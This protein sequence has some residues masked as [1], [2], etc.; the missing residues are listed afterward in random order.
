MSAT[1]GR[2]RSLLFLLVPAVFLVAAALMIAWRASAP[3]DGTVVTV[4]DA[5]V[6][7]DGVRVTADTGGELWVGDEIVAIDGTELADRLAG[8][9]GGPPVETG[10][11]LSYDVLRDGRAITVDVRLEPAP[12][13]DSLLAGWPSLLVTALLLLTSLAIFAARPRD[14]AAHAAITASAIGIATVSGAGYFQVE[15]IDL[16]AGGQFWRWFAGEICFALLWAAMLHFALAFPA[17]TDRRNYRRR[18]LAGYAGSPLLYAMLGGFAFLAADDPVSRLSL[19][20]SPALGALAVYPLLIVGVLVA[21]YVRHS[22][23]ML[24]RRLRWLATSLGGGALIYLAVWTI[25]AA[26]SGTPLV[27]WE[28]QTLA[29]LAVPL[30]VAMAIVRHRAL[31]IEVVISRSLVYGALSV[32]L[33][34]L[35]AGVVGL[36]HL[37]FGGQEQLWQQA[38]AAAI[39]AMAV[40]PLHQLLQSLVNR[41]LF[42]EQHDPY[43]VVSSLADRLENIGAPSEQLPVMVETIGTAL[44]LPYVAIELEREI[45]N[46]RVAAFGEPTTNLHSLPLSYQREIIGHLVIG[47]RRRWDGLGR[48]ERQVLEEVARHAGT[49]VYTAKLTA[50]LI[51]SRDRLVQAR[52]EERKRVQ[53][54]L[55]DGVG[56]TLAAVTFGLH[57]I[58]KAIG[59]ASPAAPMLRRLQD[60]LNGA[61]TE[62][63]RLAHGLRPPALDQVGLLAATREYLETVG[64]STGQPRDLHIEFEAPSS[65]P[66]LPPAV[67]V[68]AYRIVCEAVTNVRRHAQASNCTVR[69][70]ADDDL[71]IAV[72]DDGVGIA[73]GNGAGSGIGLRSMRERTTE[74]GGRFRIEHPRSGGTSMEVLLP[75]GRGGNGR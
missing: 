62:V 25:P 12:V 19:A 47:R 54:E 30:A 15:A 61:T 10:Q 37:L 20:G 75:I 43:R 11:V 65:L 27:P 34:T 69:L 26:V 46:E 13:G 35:Y 68:A 73:D 60:S 1:P 49:I 6:S 39:I 36:L 5:A 59:E 17:I 70:R 64:G 45:G 40:R 48:R 67:D 8:G 53:R 21:K 24:R 66:A 29:F 33:V 51:R 63:R 41:R 14:P 9:I 52:E 56:P 18:V 7:S 44:R 72:I 38:A 50:D 23:V 42:G 22:D 28:Y 74:L 32:A 31:N 4:G 16:V 2:Q 58:R 3:S 55:H 71:H 57:A